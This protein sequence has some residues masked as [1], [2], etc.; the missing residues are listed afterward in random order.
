MG[1]QV[2]Q[3]V[4]AVL[5]MD[6]LYRDALL[7]LAKMSWSVWVVLSSIVLVLYSRL[8]ETTSR[9]SIPTTVLA[10]WTSLSGL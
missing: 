1:V 3:C 5:Y 7:L 4:H 8:S 2:L 9:E 6:E 10:L